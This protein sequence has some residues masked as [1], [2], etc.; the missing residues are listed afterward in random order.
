[1][2]L[3]FK[4]SLIIALLIFLT[5]LKRNQAKELF[6]KITTSQ[7]FPKVFWGLVLGAGLP[8]SG[9]FTSIGNI[10]D[11]YNIVSNI[12]FLNTMINIRGIHFVGP[13][14]GVFAGGI[15]GVSSSPFSI[16]KILLC[17]CAGVIGGMT[18]TIY[19][20][21]SEQPHYLISTNMFSVAIFS[22]SIMP[23][24][25][26]IA[27]KSLFKA[28]VGTMAGSAAIFLFGIIWYSMTFDS[29]VWGEIR[30][31]VWQYISCFIG[32]IL[33]VMGIEIVEVKEILLS[34]TKTLIKK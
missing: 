4:I 32:G 21:L 8:F 23:I 9:S 15:I 25:I 29:M 16:K 22:L 27:D 31:P 6:K 3:V 1:M 17:L 20:F 2:L 14:F 18:Y 24:G 11:T 10:F 13:L 26:G 5:Y 12:K 30:N 34:K 33:I 7:L 19:L 28:I